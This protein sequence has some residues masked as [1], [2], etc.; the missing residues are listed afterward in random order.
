[1]WRPPWSHR[2]ELTQPLCAPFPPSTPAWHTEAWRGRE[3]GI[4]SSLR[5]LEHRKLR[6]GRNEN[7]IEEYVA[8]TGFNKQGTWPNLFF[9][10]DYLGQ[11]TEQTTKDSRY[12]VITIAQAK[13]DEV[14]G[15][16]Q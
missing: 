7:G 1:M 9:Q 2:Q 15:L 5:S 14:Q 10:N 12:V 4:T 11:Q 3:Q 8:E 16:G 6:E 13:D